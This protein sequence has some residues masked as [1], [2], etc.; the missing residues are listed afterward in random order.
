[1]K[2]RGTG[3]VR[4]R[5][6]PALLLWQRLGEKKKNPQHS[7]D[8]SIL[9]SHRVNEA[10]ITLLSGSSKWFDCSCKSLGKVQQYSEGHKNMTHH[11]SKSVNIR[12]R[13][14]FGRMRMQTYLQSLY[15]RGPVHLA[16]LG[17][18]RQQNAAG[19]VGV[20]LHRLQHVVHA[21]L[22]HTK[23]SSHAKACSGMR[24][25]YNE[26]EILLTRCPF[27]CCQSSNY[28]KGG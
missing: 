28:N 6:S 9:D 22:W 23:T 17:Y 3:L 16:D 13:N 19:F 25:D 14:L 21:D 20:L 2:T 26:C 27:N 4:L 8:E 15:C 18:G 1:M 10:I 11:D 7:S 12:F 24:P 5:C